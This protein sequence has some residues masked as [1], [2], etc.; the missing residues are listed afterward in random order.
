MTVK[1]IGLKRADTIAEAL[2]IAQATVGTNRRQT[3]MHIPPLFMY[4]VS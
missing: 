3:C 1:R 2:E 4:E